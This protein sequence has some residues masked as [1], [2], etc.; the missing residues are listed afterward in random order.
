[1]WFIASWIMRRRY[2]SLPFKM[3]NFT[4]SYQSECRE[5]IKEKYHSIV[6]R[7]QHIKT[8]LRLKDAKER[9]QNQITDITGKRRAVERPL[10]TEDEVARITHNRFGYVLALIAFVGLETFFYSFFGSLLLPKEL[11]SAYAVWFLAFGLATVFAALLHFGFRWIF[12]Y[13]EA[14]YT[15][16][17]EK[18]PAT[19]IKRF[20]PY[21]ILGIVFCV[22]FVIVNSAIGFLRADLLD[23]VAM[24]ENKAL[25]EKIHGPWRVFAVLFTFVVALLMAALEKEIASKR[26][27]WKV[28]K[29]WKRQQKERKD[30]N[31]SVRKMLDDS[32]SAKALAI[33]KYW[34][35]VK[36]LQRVFELEVDDD[37]QPRLQELN[38]A[39]GNESGFV[40]KLSDERYQYFLPVAAT[41]LGLFSKAVEDDPEIRRVIA[42]LES[43]VGLIEDFEVRNATETDQADTAPSAEFANEGGATS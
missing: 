9:M 26:N 39:L 7:L 16:E 32:R 24:S 22:L 3:R 15:I 18:L 25:V 14:R 29:N 27:R 21:F 2:Q 33:E 40:S 8:R 5:E 34:A 23:P 13:F 38:E 41:H 17:K 19:E 31:T 1:M 42:E 12:D 10:F 11:R 30:Y 28:Y 36:D 37:M 4:E 20:F 35:V 6:S 43:E